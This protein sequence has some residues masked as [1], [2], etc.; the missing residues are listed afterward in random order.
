MVYEICF[1]LRFTLCRIGQ[2]AFPVYALFEHMMYIMESLD[3]MFRTGLLIECPR[4]ATPSLLALISSC[5]EA[6]DW[7]ISLFY[8][9]KAALIRMNVDSR[10][11]SFYLWW[12]IS[13]ASSLTLSVSKLLCKKG[14]SIWNLQSSVWSLLLLVAG[15]SLM[16]SEC[17]MYGIV[18][19]REQEWSET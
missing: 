8:N 6:M 10:W 9:H 15:S 11:E 17:Q 13:S 18:P 2:L 12:H 14:I 1:T 4:A 16:D 3:L 19:W 5:E 7:A